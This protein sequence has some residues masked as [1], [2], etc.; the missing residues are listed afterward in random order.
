VLVPLIERLAIAIANDA[1]GERL[2]FY[3]NYH[4]NLSCTY[5]LTSSSPKAK[6]RELDVATI[7]AIAQ[8]AVRLG[9]RA[10]GVTGGEPFMRRDMPELVAELGRYLPTV[11]LTNGTL[12]TER[13]VSERLAQLAS[14]PVA[15]QLSIDS[16]NSDEHDRFRG[17]GSHDAALSALVRLHA[18][19]IRARVGTTRDDEADVAAVAALR[20]LVA[21]YGVSG[22]DHVV[23]PIVARGAAVVAKLGIPAGPEDVPAELTITIDG[24]FWS[25]A[26]PTVRSGRLDT[27]ERVSRVITP[28]DVAVDA[29]LRYGNEVTERTKRVA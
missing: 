5:C 21:R 10:F 19:G 23:R 26:S 20:Q 7:R 6:K 24:A 3:T 22:N 4:C 2:W 17:P 12:F 8:D 29:L 25:P 1:I 16:A 27:R 18:H 11:V 13:F 9:F 14:L 28:L 15:L